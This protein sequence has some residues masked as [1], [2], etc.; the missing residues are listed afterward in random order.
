M[1]YDFEFISRLLIIGQNRK[2]C[3]K[4]H[5]DVEYNIKHLYAKD[6]KRLSEKAM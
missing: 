2:S 4:S 1:T 6:G 3:K 5:V